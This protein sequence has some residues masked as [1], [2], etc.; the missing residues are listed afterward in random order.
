MQ[1]TYQLSNAAV[2]VEIARFGATLHRFEVAGRNIVISRPDPTKTVMGYLGA[3][4]GRYANRLAD[5]KFSIDGVGYQADRNEGPHTLHGGSGGYSELLWDEISYAPERLEL[6]LASPDGDMG[7]PGNLAVRAV[8]T[9]LPDGLRIEYS[10]STDAP[11]VINLTAHPYFNLAGEGTIDEHLLQVNS[12]EY[13]PVNAALIPSGVADSSGTALDFRTQR[14]IAEAR[15]AAIVT[16]LAAGDGFDHNLIVAGEG[17]RDHVKLTGGG[18]TLTVR[19]D[20]PAVQ[21]YDGQHFDGATPPPYPKYAGVAI[22]PQNYPDA[23]NHAEFP[24]AVLRP[25]EEYRRVI[26]YLVG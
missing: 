12:H 11:T 14:L 23:P 20:A 5:G 26:E 17:M 19:S 6:G 13:T 25:G 22:E 10:A 1:D 2:A 8:F 7:F 9:V 24:S 21:V 18:L 15:S 16:G 3:S 4:V